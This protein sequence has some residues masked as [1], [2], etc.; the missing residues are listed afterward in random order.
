MFATIIEKIRAFMY[1]RY[2]NDQLNV[3]LTIF[4]CVLTLILSFLRLPFIVRYICYIPYFIALFRALSKNIAA[5]QTENQ[6]FM[7]VSAP[8]R[9]YLAEKMRQYQ[10]KNHKY[11]HCPQCHNVLRVPKGRGKIKIS[12]PHCQKEF[13]RNTGKT[14]TL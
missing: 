2:G 8:W 5:R 13:I 12:C 11:Y 10:D 4:G 14:N 1:G 3:A 9:K 6:K 7:K